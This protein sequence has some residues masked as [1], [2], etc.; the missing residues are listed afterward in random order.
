MADLTSMLSRFLTSL[1]AG[2][3]ATPAAGAMGWE[4]RAVMKSPADGIITLLN[5]AENG[6]TRLQFGGTS[7]SFPAIKRNSA[8][9]E[10]KVADDSAYTDVNMNSLSIAAATATPAGGSQAARIVF[11]TTAHL[12]IYFGSGAPT[13]SAAQ[14][15]LYIRTDGSSTSTRMYINTNGAT[16]WTNVTTAA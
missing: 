14:G 11:G 8:S 6:F 7:A 2:N 1:Y 4:T 9:L 12:G 13:V 5:N 15:S 3:E 10:F 16:T